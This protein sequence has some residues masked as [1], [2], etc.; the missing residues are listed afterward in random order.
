ML[1]DHIDTPT[2]TVAMQGWFSNEMFGIETNE[3]AV[4]YLHR[5]AFL[6]QSNASI[7]QAVDVLVRN[8]RSA[9]VVAVYCLAQQETL[10]QLNANQ[11]LVAAALGFAGFAIDPVGQ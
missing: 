2:F 3:D 4:S 6:T 11:V 9:L 5:L 7:A 10:P 8:P 1:V